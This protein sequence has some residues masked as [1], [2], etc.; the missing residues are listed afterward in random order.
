MPKSP[1]IKR[2]LKNVDVEFISL[3]DSAANQREV[4]F[5]SEGGGEPDF[6]TQFKIRKMDSEKQLVYGAVYAPDE[7]DS[8]G[9]GMI[10]EE[11]EKA[12]HNFLAKA[13]TQNVDKQHDYKAG[14]GIVV[15]SFVLKGEHPDFPGEKEGTWAVVIKVTNE[16]TWEAVKKGELKGISLAG[17]AQAEEVEEHEDSLEKSI[18]QFLSP[19]M[20][21]F[22]EIIEKFRSQNKN[23]ESRPVEKDFQD[24]MDQKMI[25]EAVWALE[26]E[27]RSIFD[28]EDMEDK[29]AAIGEQIDK[30]KDYISKLEL[31][32]NDIDKSNNGTMSTEEKE[33]KK[34][35]E[36]EEKS[37]DEKETKPVEKAEKPEGEDELS[38]LVKAQAKTIEEL[39]GKVEKLEK[40]A[41][42]R[43]TTDDEE[44]LEKS[45]EEYNS[46]APLSFLG[47]K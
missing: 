40:A 4:I 44:D 37:A 1:K 20:K 24:R 23:N 41:P 39:K 29:K 18:E 8:H 5:K 31:G 3:V 2:Y 45:D 46:K 43:Q 11:I 15:E 32:G 9:D 21:S 7:A 16:D 28:D 47:G 34:P 42:G 10:A 25:Y 36:Q 26:S 30:F 12:A 35:A 14:E 38:E 22:K 13:R 6:T 17:K 27:F 33:T 19:V